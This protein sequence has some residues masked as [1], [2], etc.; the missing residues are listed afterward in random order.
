MSPRAS[1]RRL[2]PAILLGTLAC[3]KDPA[4]PPAPITGLPRDL[5]ATE[6][7][8]ALASNALA[9]DLLRQ[10]AADPSGNSVIAPLSVSMALGM[11]M[12]GADGVTLDQMRL[13]LRHASPST[14]P[15]TLS[16][17]NAAYRG[18][19]ELLTGLDRSTTMRVANGIWYRTGFTPAPGFLEATRT[20]FDAAVRAVDFAD[21]RTLGEINGWVKEQTSGRIPTILESI[22]PDDVM[23]LINAMYFKGA[24]QEPFDPQATRSASFAAAGGAQQVSMM[25]RQGQQRI[26]FGDQYATIDLPYGNGAFAMTIVLPNEGVSVQSV[27]ET[28]TADRW[29]AMIGELSATAATVKADLYLP[30]FILAITRQLK[31][32]LTALGMAELFDPTRANLSRLATGSERLYVRFV[33]HKTFLEVN[34]AGTEAAGVTGI[35]VGVTSLPPQ[36]R[37]DRPFLLAIRERFSGTILFL[38]KIVRIPA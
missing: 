4:G 34:E 7:R 19:F 21:G 8:L 25:Y 20:H 24:W 1:F 12:N 22:H 13:A 28:M 26:R 29:E 23:Y 36:F 17:M 32:D 30:K 10:T 3:A 14:T 9:F 15:P 31:D 18:L 11:L 38:G 27:V 33:T 5:T 35:G 16:E 37:V 6:S 2:L